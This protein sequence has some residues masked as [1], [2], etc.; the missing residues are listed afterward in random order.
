MLDELYFNLCVTKVRKLKKECKTM[1]PFIRW[2][3]KIILWAIGTPREYVSKTKW[4]IVKDATFK[5]IYD[6][7]DKLTPDKLMR[8]I[9]K[10]SK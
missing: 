10:A 6:K 7:L 5:K 8:K 1:Y 4:E 2:T 3:N 9:Y